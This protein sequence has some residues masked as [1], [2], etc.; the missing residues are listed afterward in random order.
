MALEQQTEFY[1]LIGQ[2]APLREVLDIVEK[3]AD[4]SSTIVINGESGTGKEM[5]ARALHYNSRRRDKSFIPINCA[6]IPHDLMES[7][8]FGHE[9]GAFTGAVNARRGRFELAHQGTLFL[10][11][12]GDL[13]LSLQVKLLRVLA[14]NEIDR[15]GGT[16]SI[17]IDVRIIAATHKNL[18]KA[19]EEGSFRE[20]LYYRLNVIPIALPPL[21]ERKSDIAILAKHFLQTINLAKKKSVKRIDDRAMDILVNYAWPGNIRELANFIERMVVLSDGPT[22]TPADL[23]A[24]VLDGVPKEKWTRL[25]DQT[26]SES[27]AEFMRQNNRNSFMAG[28]PA[29]G[30][31]L[32]KTVEE[33]EK[34]LILEA[35]AKTNWV[36][37]K[38]AVLLGLNRTTLVEKLKK[39]KI[40]QEDHT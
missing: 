3:A 10:D 23:P 7:E 27:A 40:R 24:K 37:N 18:E 4:T 1:Q 17:K 15:I 2:S 19:I 13:T 22:L 31:N 28:L 39:M 30:L 12:I 9:K 34:G 25:P 38:A 29:G 32:K 5:I 11:E 20:D 8:L 35:L 16:Q 33:F 36:K 21:R 26:P 14:E 6:A